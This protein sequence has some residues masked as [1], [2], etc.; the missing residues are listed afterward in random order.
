GNQMRLQGQGDAG[1]NGGPYGD[2]YIIFRVKPSDTFER[3]GAEIFYELPIN[4]VQA[5]LGDE[6][7][8]PTVHGKVKLKIP[9]GTQNGTTFR[10]KG[11]GAP[12]LR[13]TGNGDQH[14][15]IN[16]IIPS[17]LNEKQAELLRQYADASGMD[18]KEQ[19]DESFFEKVKDVFRDK[20][21]K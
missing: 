13:R 7:E 8:V 19:T 9:A 20:G 12:R 6:V 1:L 2:L 5:S 11:K 14:I 3:Q 15:K 10:L 21:K 17:T 4:F 16:V 18:V